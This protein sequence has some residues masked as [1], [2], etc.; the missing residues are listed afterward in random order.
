[1][2]FFTKVMEPYREQLT[3][4]LKKR[5][6]QLHI[7]GAFSVLGPQAAK[8]PDQDVPVS[9]LK[10]LAAKFHLM[11]EDALLEEWPSFKEHL[12]TGV[13]KVRDILHS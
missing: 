5:F 12:L 3:A 2:I 9:H 10:T 13:L 6:Q 1:M 11:D 4:E 7:L 8:S